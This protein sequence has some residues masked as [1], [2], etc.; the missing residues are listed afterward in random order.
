MSEETT[1]VQTSKRSQQHFQFTVEFGDRA[2]RMI[3]LQSLSGERFRGSF[4]IA[5]V[6]SGSHNQTMGQ[7]PNLPG[8]HLAVSTRDRRITISD[9]LEHDKT[10]LSQLRLA[11]RKL[12]SIREAEVTYV[13]STE[14]QLDEDALKTLL[15]ELSAMI[16]NK[17]ATVIKG[18]FP[19]REQIEQ[20][21]GDELWDPGD[22]TGRPKPRYKKDERA[23][24]NRQAGIMV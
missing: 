8:Q 13:P 17:T 18:D 23:W 4:A 10:L 15:F 9:P 20:L 19:T 21:A 7:I 5:N 6:P 2:N 3:V 1:T 22:T 24:R 16:A 12:R 11:M 14:R